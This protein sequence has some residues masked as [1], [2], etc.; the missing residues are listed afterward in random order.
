MAPLVIAPRFCGP[1]DMGLASFLDGNG[2]N[3]V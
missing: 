3:A 1:P 2:A